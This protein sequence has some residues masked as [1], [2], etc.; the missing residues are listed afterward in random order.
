MYIRMGI[1][2]VWSLESPKVFERR[3]VTLPVAYIASALYEHP[4]S[5]LKY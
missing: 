3:G 2:L 1:D 5:K 4:Y